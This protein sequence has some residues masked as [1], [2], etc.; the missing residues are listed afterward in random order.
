M[1]D[2]REFRRPLSRR[3]PNAM[4]RPCTDDDF[5]AIFAIINEAAQAYRGVIPADRWHDPYMPRE[6]LRHEI[7]CGVRFWGWEDGGQLA[8]VMGIQDVQDVTLIRHAYVRTVQRNKGIGGRLLGELRTLT[9]RPVLIGTWADAVWAIRFYQKH[10]FRLVTPEEKNRL[11]GRYWSIP[12][13]QVETSVVL[14]DPRWFGEGQAVSGQADPSG[15]K[16]P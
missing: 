8:G 4:I 1:L 13:R 15:P 9:T 12:E 2:E 11:L 10:G 16:T 14:G 3:N 7:Q 5:D 6:E